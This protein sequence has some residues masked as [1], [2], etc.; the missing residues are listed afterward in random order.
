MHRRAARERR[1]ADRAHLLHVAHAA[2]CDHG[3]HAARLRGRREQPAEHGGRGAAR[4]ADHDHLPDLGRVHVAER[5]LLHGRAVRG[6][7]LDC[8]RWPADVDCQRVLEPAHEVHVDEVAL[9]LHLR[10]GVRDRARRRLREAHEHVR[11]E[12]HVC[13]EHACSSGRARERTRESK[14]NE[15]RTRGARDRE[16]RGCGRRCSCRRRCRRRGA[17]AAT[18]VAGGAADATGRRAL[19]ALE[20]RRAARLP[21]VLGEAR[22]VGRVLLLALFALVAH[23]ALAVLRVQALEVVVH[24]AWLAAHG[25]RGARRASERASARERERESEN[26]RTHTSTKSSRVRGR[27]ERWNCL[28]KP[29]K[30]DKHRSFSLKCECSASESQRL[31]SRLR[32]LAN[33]MACFLLELSS[34]PHQP[35]Y[36]FHRLQQVMKAAQHGKTNTH[37]RCNMLSSQLPPA[38]TLACV[39]RQTHHGPAAAD[40]VTWTCC[41]CSAQQRAQLLRRALALARLGRE[42]RDSGRCLLHAVADRHELELVHD[43]SVHVHRQQRRCR[44]KALAADQ[45][46]C[47]HRLGHANCELCRRVGTAQVDHERLGPGM[48]RGASLGRRNERRKLLQLC[49]QLRPDAACRDHSDVAGRDPELL[50]HVPH[51]QHRHAA[52]DVVDD[53]RDSRCAASLHLAAEA[54]RDRCVAGEQRQVVGDAARQ[55]VEIRERERNVL[56]QRA[57]RRVHAEVLWAS[58][59]H[60]S[61]LLTALEILRAIQCRRQARRRE[62]NALLLVDRAGVFSAR[63]VRGAHDDPD[64]RSSE[65]AAPAAHESSARPRVPLRRRC[66]THTHERVP[67]LQRAARQLLAPHRAGVGA[68]AR[69]RNERSGGDHRRLAPHLPIAVRL[70][71]SGLVRVLVQRRQHMA[72]VVAHD[73]AE[74]VVQRTRERP[75]AVALDQ[76][77]GQLLAREPP[78]KLALGI[79]QL[80]RLFLL[81]CGGRGHRVVTVRVA[82]PAVVTV[83]RS[84]WRRRA[85]CLTLT[86][87]AIS[88]RR[89]AGNFAVC[90]SS[91]ALFAVGGFR[92]SCSGSGARALADK[93]K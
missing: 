90:C 51:E 26:A 38:P 36:L 67:A 82:F 89:A 40:T 75:E 17:A 66:D 9:D 74:A 50:V 5:Q 39:D 32:G 2:V 84:R 33:S 23:E 27:W 52:S 76:R 91:C 77:D 62:Y 68:C 46:E 21:E 80:V 47:A 43:N 69:P 86:A 1:E 54:K 83:C 34:C 12:R 28:K 71:L 15:Q 79:L 6:H 85:N 24:V 48:P 92:P 53:D 59:L 25:D 72:D 3:S 87:L 45:H 30:R 31:S 60:R 11:V 13:V 41:A 37:S 22:G 29:Q 65:H 88:A 18:A 64:K 57:A 35:S 70:R 63:G 19:V 81:S 7:H 14:E 42:I 16:R 78:H 73:R 58:A 44:L 93:L 55:R 20:G 56:A 49:L 8:H 4:R 10:H 61:L